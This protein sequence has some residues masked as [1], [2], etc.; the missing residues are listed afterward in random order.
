[1]ILAGVLLKLGGY[2]L[3]RVLP[4]F[5][6][7]NSLVSWLWVRISLVGGFVIRLICLRQTDIKALIAYSSVAHIGLILAGLIVARSWAVRGA[8]AVMLGHGFCSSGLFCLANIVY[9]RVGRRRL[10][11]NKGLMNFMPRMAL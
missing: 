9:E 6:C 3:I 4:L 11:I 7:V 8:V 2:G 1:M 10:V 5:I